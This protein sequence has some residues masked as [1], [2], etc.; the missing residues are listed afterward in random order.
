MAFVVEFGDFVLVGRCGDRF[1]VMM[2]GLGK[3]GAAAKGESQR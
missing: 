2:F 1:I 3:G